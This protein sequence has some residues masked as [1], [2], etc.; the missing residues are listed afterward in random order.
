MLPTLYVTVTMCIHKY[1]FAYLNFQF[2]NLILHLVAHW[3]LISTY[4]PI[5]MY[6]V[7]LQLKTALQ[8]RKMLNT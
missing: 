1:Q 3:G 4:K 8:P 6:L 5:F 7:L 2:V